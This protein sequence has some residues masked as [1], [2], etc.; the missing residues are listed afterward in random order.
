MSDGIVASSVGSSLMWPY[1][2]ASIACSTASIEGPITMRPASRSASPPWNAGSP[3]SAKFTLKELQAFLSD[4]LGKHE[5]IHA[6]EFRAE[7]PRT[8]VGKISKKELYDEEERKAKTQ[9]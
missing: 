1:F 2:T 9:A 7:L 4:K 3:D 8:A 6:L 5:M